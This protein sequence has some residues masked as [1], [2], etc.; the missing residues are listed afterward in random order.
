MWYRRNLNCEYDNYFL[1]N[2]L[3]TSLKIIWIW[4]NTQIQILITYENLN[5]N[6]YI[7]NNCINYLNYINWVYLFEIVYIF[8]I[9]L[10]VLGNKLIFQY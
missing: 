1:L 9:E 6:R 4:K 5:G 7:N 2:S 10:C 3:G 8:L